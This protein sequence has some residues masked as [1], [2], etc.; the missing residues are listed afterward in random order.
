M[1][2]YREHYVCGIA[3]VLCWTISKNSPYLVVICP[4]DFLNWSIVD[5]VVL[6]SGVFK[7]CISRSSDRLNSMF[8]IGKMPKR[9]LLKACPPAAAS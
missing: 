4:S 2:P 5:Y 7:G 8:T 1:A 9:N 6:V 3:C